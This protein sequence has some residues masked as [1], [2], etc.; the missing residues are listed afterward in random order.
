MKR[1]LPGFVLGLMI[2]PSAGFTYQTLSSNQAAHQDHIRLGADLQLGASETDVRKSLA[3]GYE[4]RKE[5][6]GLGTNK[7]SWLVTQKGKPEILGVITFK[8]GRLHFATKRWLSRVEDQEA[9]VRTARA[10]YG[11]ISDFVKQ[12]ETSCN[13]KSDHQ[14][15]PTFS[16]QIASVVCGSKHLEILVT[17]APG[18]ADSVDINESL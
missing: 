2:F 1:F 8:D 16:T 7:D 11:V 6:G 17:S 15:T 4:L 18:N 3:A 10:I 5:D 12:G 13:I 14:E 9:D